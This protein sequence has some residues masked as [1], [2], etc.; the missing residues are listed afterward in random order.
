M[1]FKQSDQLFF[2]NKEKDSSSYKHIRHHLFRLIKHKKYMPF[3]ML[4]TS[5]LKRK[6]VS[7]II[8]KQGLIFWINRLLSSFT[9]FKLKKFSKFKYFYF[10]FNYI[11][12]FL[13]ISFTI[14]LF[15]VLLISIKK[16]MYF[17]CL[18]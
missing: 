13:I 12:F 3:F 7:Q 6:M 18:I 10:L 2:N 8:K 14:F 15:K 17:L 5:T 1:L 11:F 9:K 4:I 16:G